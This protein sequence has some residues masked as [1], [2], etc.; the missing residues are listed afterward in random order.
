MTDKCM[1]PDCTKAGDYSRGH[2]ESHYQTVARF[3]RQQLTSWEEQERLGRVKR[4]RRPAKHFFLEGCKGAAPIKE[5][6]VAVPL[7]EREARI[8]EQLRAV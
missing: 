7:T 6:T 5:R 3:V 4:T 8:I 2:C 1:T